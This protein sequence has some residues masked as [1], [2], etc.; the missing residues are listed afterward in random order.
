MQDASSG[1]WLLYDG[2]CPFCSA[3]VSYVRLRETAGP[4]PLLN[5]RTHLD[6][7]EEAKRQ[8]FDL[9]VGMVLKLDGR[10]YH[11]ADCIN[12]LALLT[13]PS[14]FF[15]RLNR[16]IFRS[17]AISRVLYPVMRGGR[18]LALRLLGRRQLRE[19]PAGGAS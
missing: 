6:R 4:V 5:A 11:G 8:G 13:T 10:Y 9:D 18:N 3:Y 2:D 16:V 7:V 1:N 14:G 12:A 15:N 17:R 19:N